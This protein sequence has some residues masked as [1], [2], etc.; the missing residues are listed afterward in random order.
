MIGDIWYVLIVYGSPLLVKLIIQDVKVVEGPM[1][2]PIISLTERTYLLIK[3][4]IDLII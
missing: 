3:R 4:R 1:C 2:E